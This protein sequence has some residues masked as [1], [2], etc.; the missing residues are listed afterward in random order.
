[1]AIGLFRVGCSARVLAQELCVTC[2]TAWTLLTTLRTVPATDPHL[3]RLAGRVEVDETYFGGRRKGKHGRGAAGKSPVVGLRQRD[4]QVR[5]LVIPNVQSQ[6]LRAVIR[7]HVTP[8]QRRAHR[9]VQQ[10]QPGPAG[11]VPPPPHRLQG[12]LAEA[13]FKFNTRKEP[14]FIGLMLSKLIRPYPPMG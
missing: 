9:P 8:R 1:L 11:R 4:G 10:L 5:S 6:T 12:Y 14:D 3:T 7:Q 13:D 2:K